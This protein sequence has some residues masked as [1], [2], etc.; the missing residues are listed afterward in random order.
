MVGRNKGGLIKCMYSEGI[1]P[2]SLFKNYMATRR[3]RTSASR[4]TAKSASI[5]KEATTP[6]ATVKKVTTT[7]PKSATKV[8]P[9]KVTTKVTPKEVIE[10]TKVTNTP[11]VETLSNTKSLLNDYPRDIFALFL[12]PL[13]LLEA[14]TKEILKQTGVLA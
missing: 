9:K 1:Q 2:H 7:A 3:T 13:F 6:R 11:K 12:L 14:G 4:K 10:V 5:T 8:T